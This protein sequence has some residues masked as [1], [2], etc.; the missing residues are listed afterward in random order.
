MRRTLL[1][2]LLGCLLTTA[3]TPALPEPD[4]RDV[5]VEL[6]NIE[7]ASA[8]CGP[9]HVDERLAAA[10]QDHSQ[11]MAERDYLSHESPEGEGPRERA[12]RHGYPHLVA[13][14]VARGQQSAER[15]VETWMASERHRAII[16]NCD[17]VAVG[18]GEAERA[19]TQKLGH[20]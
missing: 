7:R 8:G 13:E 4:E 5:V 11:D 9:V 18:V 20:G 16:L 1:P 15:V 14:T 2:L 10:A 19:W 12:D 3:A 6:V 17:R